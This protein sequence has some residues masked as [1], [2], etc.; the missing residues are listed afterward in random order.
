M[1]TP[2]GLKSN[3]GHRVGSARSR[4]GPGRRRSPPASAADS[5]RPSWPPPPM[6]KVGSGGHRRHA[7]Q[8]RMGLSAADS[9]ARAS[10]I[11][12]SIASVSSARLTKV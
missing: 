10:G 9:S 1:I 2:Y 7:G 3:A 12:Q 8:P 11:G 6:T 4:V 5:A